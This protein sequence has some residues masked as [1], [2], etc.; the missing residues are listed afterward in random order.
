MPD[1]VLEEDGETFIRYYNGDRY[2]RIRCVL[3]GIT[4]DGIPVHTEHL[5]EVSITRE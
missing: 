1:V 3:E 5:Y 4:N 2:T